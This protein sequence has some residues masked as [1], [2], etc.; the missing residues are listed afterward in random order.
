MMGD[1]RIMKNDL[2][3][4]MTMMVSPDLY[5]QLTETPEEALKRRKQIYAQFA[6]LAVLMKRAASRS[7]K[8]CQ[9]PQAHP[10]RCGCEDPS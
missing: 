9:Q 3:P 7:P 5:Q 8:P 10:A 1:I 2:L 6:G 4:P